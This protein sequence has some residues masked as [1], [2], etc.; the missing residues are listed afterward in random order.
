LTRLVNLW[1]R[2]KL[3]VHLM[4]WL[5]VFGILEISA[6][7]IARVR[8][9]PEGPSLPTHL[10][11]V[12]ADKQTIWRYRPNFDSYYVV[13][14]ATVQTKTNSLGIHD[15]E[16]TEER[17]NAKNRLL[18][19][20]DSFTFGWG[21][22]IEATFWKQLQQMLN[23]RGL[24]GT[25]EVFGLGHW[26]ATFSQHVLHLK[27]HFDL[28]KPHVVVWAIYPGHLITIIS[29]R[30]ILDREGRL[31]S[32]E[33]PIVTV[34]D[35]LLLYEYDGRRFSSPLHFPYIWTFP[36][37]IL[38][39]NLFMGDYFR[40]IHARKNINWM[41]ELLPEK[42]T[43]MEQAHQKLRFCIREMNDFVKSKGSRLVVVLIPEVFQ[44][45]EGRIP[46]DMPS[47]LRSQLITAN[48][49]QDE[50]QAFCLANGIECVNP[51]N[52]FRKCPRKQELYLPKDSHFAPLG[53]KEFA[54]T[55]F[56]AMSK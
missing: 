22:P 49:P 32:V 1:R 13:D 23:S 34:K 4:I 8:F 45:L 3:G 2:K 47:E 33:D 19:V 21:I 16:W 44:V 29:H 30:L 24:D 25:W 37:R 56:N 51:L 27:R 11:M 50:I 17:L 18:A 26:M 42:R 12:V 41:D 9:R 10:P 55:L 40:L 53:H 7:L 48:F 5:S 52:T 38:N 31:E 43:L 15:G 36:R 20:G 14:G 35:N 46:N 6:F 54:G 39:Q 28:V